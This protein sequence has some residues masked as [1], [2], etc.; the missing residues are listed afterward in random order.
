M[1]ILQLL[2]FVQCLL[3]L[4]SHSR[5]LHNA[6]LQV[7]YMNILL[8]ANIFFHKIFQFN[9]HFKWNRTFEKSWEFLRIQS[10]KINIVHLAAESLIARSTVKLLRR[11]RTL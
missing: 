2:N 4:A 11:E 6:F 10:A 9:I 8:H 1:D 7:F 3:N 5:I